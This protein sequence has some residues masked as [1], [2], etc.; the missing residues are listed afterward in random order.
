MS[1]SLAAV[2]HHVIWSFCYLGVLI[3]LSAYGIHRY[4]ILYLFLKNR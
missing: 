4:C 2:F 3:G 1:E